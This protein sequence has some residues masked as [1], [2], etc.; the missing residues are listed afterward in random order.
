M[1]STLRMSELY[2]SAALTDP[3]TPVT[4]PPPQNHT[5]QPRTLAA[6]LQPHLDMFLM[7]ITWVG[8][9]LAAY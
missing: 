2:G 1:P 9:K 5:V 3:N 6:Q 4:E 8:K 7:T